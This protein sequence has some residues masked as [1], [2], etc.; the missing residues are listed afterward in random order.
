MKKKDDS[1]VGTVPYRHGQ[2]LNHDCRRKDEG[3]R[4]ITTLIGRRLKD[5]I[6]HYYVYMRNCP[7]CN[8]LYWGLSWYERNSGL[9][10]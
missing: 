10:R 8:K 9:D 7:L 4:P 1:F 5:S 6:G 3:E 2:L